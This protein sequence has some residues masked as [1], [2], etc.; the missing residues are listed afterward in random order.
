[1]NSITVTGEVHTLSPLDMESP[2]V[3]KRTNIRE[4]LQIGTLQLFLLV[5]G[6][7]VFHHQLQDNGGKDTC[8]NFPAAD[9][10]TM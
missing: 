4:N 6:T 7:S 1:M 8:C 5:I 2:K 9:C 3:Y 10:W